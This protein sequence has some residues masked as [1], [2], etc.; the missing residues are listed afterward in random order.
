MPPP[1]PGRR[2][3]G[4]KEAVFLLAKKLQAAARRG[5]STAELLEILA[6]KGLKV[7]VDTVRAALRLVG[8]GAVTSPGRSRKSAGAP[9]GLLDG[10]GS[11]PGPTSVQS[12]AGVSVGDR[13]GHRAEVGP[14]LALRL[15][16]SATGGSAEAGAESATASSR[17]NAVVSDG[18]RPDQGTEAGPD[19][20]PREGR[21]IAGEMPASRPDRAGWRPTTPFTRFSGATGF[22]R[23]GAGRARSRPRCRCQRRRRR[24]R[25]P[26][27][28]SHR[29][30]TARDLCRR[31]HP[32]APV[33]SQALQEGVIDEPF[34]R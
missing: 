12:N 23:S 7:H 15:G 11:E 21:A 5:F 20:G 19:D 1:D 17:P 25:A 9:N 14:E 2:K 16:R 18:D 8:R 32:L 27:P 13:P 3:V 29:P 33:A 24:S 22:G 34:I 10:S 6:S 26:L 31:R 28:L 30:R 4:K